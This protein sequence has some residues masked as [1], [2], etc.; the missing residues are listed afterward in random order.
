MKNPYLDDNILIA[1]KEAVQIEKELKSFKQFLKN[2]KG[3]ILAPNKYYLTLK[4]SLQTMLQQN[5]DW[6][7][8]QLLIATMQG[9]VKNP[10]PEQILTMT[11]IVLEVWEEGRNE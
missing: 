7:A 6:T 9:T 1:K 4:T 2:N 5:P 8:K 11:K 10:S 3:R